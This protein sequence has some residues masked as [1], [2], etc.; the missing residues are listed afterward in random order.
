[1]GLYAF[2]IRASGALVAE[3]FVFLSEFFVKMTSETKKDNAEISNK[4]KEYNFFRTLSKVFL[5]NNF[6]RTFTRVLS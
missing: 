6:F 3:H 1:M 4:K 5:R 2:F